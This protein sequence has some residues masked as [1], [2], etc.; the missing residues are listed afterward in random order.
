M[1]EMPNEKPDFKMV[2]RI[3]LA[4]PG[5]EEST[6]FGQPALKFKGKVFACMASHHS[7][8]PGSLVVRIDFDRRGELLADAPEIYYLTDHYVGYSGVL[9]RLAKIQPDALRGLLAGALEFVRVAAR[10]RAAP[11]TTRRR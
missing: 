10:K 3:G 11:K 1:P 8:E 2:R 7:A 6:S 5:V 4:F 9:A